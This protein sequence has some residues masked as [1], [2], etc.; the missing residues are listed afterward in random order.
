MWI[1][2]HGLGQRRPEWAAELLAAYLIDRPHAFDLDATGKVNVLKLNQPTAFELVAQSA[3]R[4][5]AEFCQLL[6]PY[7]L[8]VMRLTEYQ[9]HVRPIVDR[10]FSYRHPVNGPVHELDDALSTQ[11]LLRSAI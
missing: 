7:L 9:P 5:P 3:A 8:Q 1:G 4:A 6:V 10:H 2:A 11:Q